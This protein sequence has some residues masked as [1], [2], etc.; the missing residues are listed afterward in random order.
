MAVKHRVEK[1]ESVKGNRRL[2]EKIETWQDFIIA[3]IG[4]NRAVTAE[5]HAQ[6]EPY[7]AKFESGQWFSRDELYAIMDIFY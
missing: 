1:L 3:N 4:N 5:E 2:S 7:K 6:L